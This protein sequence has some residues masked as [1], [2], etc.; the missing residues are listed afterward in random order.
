MKSKIIIVAIIFS[1]FIG[2]FTIDTIVDHT[3]NKSNENKEVSKELEDSEMNVI[4]DNQN[5]VIDSN[6]LEQE[7]QE[8]KKNLLQQMIK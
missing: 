6:E 2:S 5:V 8:N 4:D 1:I 7:K 3:R